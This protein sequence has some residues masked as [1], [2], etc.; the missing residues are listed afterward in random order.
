MAMKEETYSIFL[1]FQNPG[2]TKDAKGQT[3]H[4][5]S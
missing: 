4:G 1:T 2:F 5:F 3:K